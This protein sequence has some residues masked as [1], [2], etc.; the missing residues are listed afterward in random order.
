MKGKGGFGKEYFTRIEGKFQMGGN[1][2]VS[3]ARRECKN[4]TNENY[5]QNGGVAR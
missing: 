3:G 1:A 4:N 2:D 5:A